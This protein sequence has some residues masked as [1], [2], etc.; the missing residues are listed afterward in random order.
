MERPSLWP[1]R[2]LACGM[3]V[4]WCVGKGLRA[5][6]VV[7]S[8]YLS[9]FILFPLL[10]PLFKIFAPL[11]RILDRGTGYKEEILLGLC[12]PGVQV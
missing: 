6:L 11:Y 8:C 5:V 2:R 10:S 7:G 4:Q 12:H 3:P 1:P 9:H